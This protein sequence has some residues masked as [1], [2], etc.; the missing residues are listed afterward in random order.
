MAGLSRGCP[1]DVG[2]DLQGLGLRPRQVHS[3]SLN[4]LSLGGLGHSALHWC[5]HWLSSLEGPV[6]D[7]GGKEA[8]SQRRESPVPWKI[9]QERRDDQLLP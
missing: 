6:S 8:A 4:W 2:R 5:L 3:M 7:R 9:H 1:E